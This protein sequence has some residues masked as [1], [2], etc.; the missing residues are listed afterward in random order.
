MNEWPDGLKVAVAA[1]V[2]VVIIA[3]VFAFVNMT[4]NA[5]QEG[6]DKL[7]DSISSFDEKSFAQ[8]DGTE[9][10]GQ[11]AIG[12]VTQFAGQAMSVEI[13]TIACPKGALFGCQVEEDLASGSEAPTAEDKQPQVGVR[14]VTWDYKETGDGE[15]AKTDSIMST[16]TKKNSPNYVNKN[17]K[18][19]SHVHRSVNGVIT[20]IHMQQVGLKD[21]V[22]GLNTAGG[23]SD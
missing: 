19:Y 20:G 1:I 22:C 17:A 7:G 18:F 13:D 8:W 11:V 5:S 9:I 21:D 23:G 6:Q 3:I 12:A 14:G 4:Q 10:S 15:L 2:L 16:L